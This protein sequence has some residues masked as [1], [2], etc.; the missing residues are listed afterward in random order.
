MILYELDENEGVLTV[1]PEGKLETQDFLALSEVVDPFI[2]E[3]GRL[4][5]III[6]TE[7]FPGWEDF[8]GMIEHMRFVRNHHRKI[9]KVALVTD[10]KIADVAESLGKHFVK[11]SIKHFFFKEL[12]SAKRWMLKAP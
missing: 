2:E 10:S 3:R 8:N 7:R 9:V 4:N 6:V 11:A 12:E 5:G 1:R